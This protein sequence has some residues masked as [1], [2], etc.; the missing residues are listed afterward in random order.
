[1]PGRS[2]E[3]IP[4]ELDARFSDESQ[5]SSGERNEAWRAYE[6]VRLGAGYPLVCMTGPRVGQD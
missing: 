4:D 2:V 3:L 5:R 6:R 1:M